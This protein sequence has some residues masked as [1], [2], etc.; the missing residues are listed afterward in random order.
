MRLPFQPI[1]RLSFAFLFILLFS[2]NRRLINLDY[3]NASG[4]IQPLT[5]LVF[6]FSK[7][8][9]ADSLT[10]R[11]DSTR[12]ISFEPSIPGRFRWE[13]G[14]ELV[15]SPSGP[16]RPATGYHAKLSNDLLQYSQADQF[17]NA[18]KID[19]HTPLLKLENADGSWVKPESGGQSAEPELDLYFN[20]PVDPSALKDKMKLTVD[21]KPVN[22]SLQTL[23]VGSKMAVRVPDLKMIDKDYDAAITLDKGM[24]PAGG[25]NGTESVAQSAASIP[26]PFVL[27][28][29]EITAN[30]ENTGGSV[31]VKTSQPVSREDLAAHISLN[32]A[33]KY[34]TELTAN[35]FVLRSDHFDA[36]KTYQITITK[37]V[38]GSIGGTLHEDYIN[39]LAFGALEPAISFASSKG[40]YL[41]GKGEKNLEVRLTNVATVKIIVSKIYENNLLAAQRSG[42]S[43]ADNNDNAGSEYDDNG[44][45]NESASPVAGDIIFTQEV[46]TRLLPK[47]GNSRIYHLDFQD[48]L[49]DFKGI[50]HIVIRSAKDYWVNDS[51]FLS[52]SDIGLMARE[53]KGKMVVFAN[54]IQTAAPLKGINVVA[55]GANNQVL[56][57]AATDDNGVAEIKYSRREFAGFKPAMIVA[58]TAD[59]FNYLPFSNTH[60]NT[61]RFDVGG[62]SLN[63]TGLDAFIYPERD[64]YRPGEKIN[65]SV[66][67]RDYNWHSPGEIPVKMKF[68]L[69]NGK[70]LKAFRKNL[71]EQGSLESSLD[72]PETAITGSYSLEV[73]SSNDVLLS[74]QAFRVEEFVPDR[75]KVTTK[76]SPEILEPGKTSTLS[77]HADN[78][79]G[80]PAADRNYECEIQVKQSGFYAKNYSNYSFS[81]TNQKTFFDKIVREGKTDAS[82]NGSEAYEV[83][84]IFRNLGVLQADFYATVFDETGRPVSRLSSAKIYTQPYFLGIADDGNYYYAL[85]KE[86][87]FSL[88][89]LD[90]QEKVLDGMKAEVS[91]IKHEYRTVLTKSGS[92]FR[93]ESQQED[94]LVSS[95]TVVVSGDKT[96]FPFTPRSSGNYEVRVTLP[97]ANSYVSRSFYSYGYFGSEN[98]SFEVNNEGEVN[99]AVDKESYLN[100]ETAKVLLKAPFDGRMLVTL[101]T[102]QIISYQYVNV[103]NKTATLNLNL[104]TEAVPNAYI[105]ATLIKPH[106]L[107]DIPLTV[108][109][110]VANIMVEEK[111]RKIAVQIEAKTAVRSRT[112]QD[113]LVK[114]APNSLVTLAVV[115]NGVLQVSGFETP[116]PY[117]YFYAKRALAVDG[118]DLYQLLLPEL[119]ARLSSTGGDQ[120]QDMNKR[121]N[122]MPAKRINIMS[123]WSG[124]KQADGSGQVHFNVDLPAF[125][126]QLRLMA[127]AYRNDQ[128]GSVASTMTVAD[129]LVLSTALPRFLTPS[130]SARV[131][132]TVTNTTSAPASG[133][134]SLKTSGGLLVGGENPQVITLAAHSEKRVYFDVIAKPEIGIGKVSV[135]VNGLGEKFTDETEIGVR[136]AASLQKTT[137]SGRLAAGTTEPV[138]FSTTD[139]IPSSL[140]TELLISRFP[141]AGLG[142]YLSQLLMYPYGCTEQTVSSA[143]PQLYYGDLADALQIKNGQ[144]NN[145]NYNVQEAI[146]KIRMRQ[147]YNG[148]VTLWDNEGSANWWT[149][150]YAAH[151]LVEAGKAGFDVDKGLLET[152][153][154]YLNGQLRN[155]KTINYYYNRDKNKKIVPKEVIYSLYVLA[156]NGKPNMPV[157]NYYK[158]SPAL[159]SLDCKYLLAAAYALAGD[160]ASFKQF[161]PGAFAGEES[162]AE[163]GG[164]FYS[165]IRDEAIALDVLADVDP[166]NPQVALMA[167]HVTDKLNQRSWYSTQ[168]L[169]FS[170]LGLGKIARQQATSQATA[171]VR[172]NGKT[173]AHF[174][175]KDLRLGT[176]ELKGGLP[177]IVGQGKGNL[178]YYWEQEGIPVS[179]PMTESDSYLKIRKHFFDRFGRPLTGTGFKQNELIIVQLTLEKSFSGS[180]ENIVVSDLLPAGFEIENPRTK[181]IPGMEWIKDAATPSALD[182]RDDR[183]NLFVDAYSAK[184]NYYYAVRAV[185]PG[186]Y[187]MGPVSADAMYNGEYH[188]YRNGGTIRITE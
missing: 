155:R 18:G 58:K 3:T 29:N 20:Y 23:S 184:Q 160:K 12:Y 87:R 86:M 130:D 112:K 150:V 124:I 118:Y 163:T 14:D 108:A 123:Y 141:A 84:E 97:G 61:S 7:A 127:V 173:V 158:A 98:S 10:N 102:N 52:L 30:Q 159:L 70:E 169:A 65:F 137:G 135:T 2:C 167:K 83:Q 50:Y 62:K 96:S 128:F 35:G 147:L 126:G 156:L 5:N 4:E 6:R 59:D 54:S 176:A 39:N 172:V 36:D 100:G 78:F 94:K 175:G 57:L 151:F 49:P 157:M 47:Y 152:M 55:Y 44:N 64:I 92:Y 105:T 161:L 37:G 68:L 99:I 168:E 24:L 119:R 41:S 69:P 80:P 139:Y 148:A 43:P 15:F 72:L 111:S 95:A 31:Q 165:D 53:G 187:K 144:R 174:A 21:G 93:Y 67:L 186:T 180:V 40:V 101:E 103:V 145:A 143:F 32:P 181:E 177:E 60:V 38:R 107:S 91:V 51:R 8:L 9:V 140:S 154:G 162:V 71:N 149:T 142:K 146:R 131:A 133:T 45:Y 120:E 178:F 33:V 116:D 48:K 17:S 138:H 188:S 66:I 85:N 183:I 46:E 136:P 75:I 110:G 77:L 104:T 122:P 170:F 25:V 19:F 125:S 22:F 129:P 153:L 132:L 1:I 73:Y 11:W 114:A 182:V 27:R 179:A 171:D 117:G 74:T 76:L 26:S 115:D 28:I 90:R 79:F 42:Y 34:S 16:L 121:T 13:H 109:H 164:S 63:A 113:I 56:G 166:G 106:G 89:A 134:A 81:L 82:G 185:S 88:I